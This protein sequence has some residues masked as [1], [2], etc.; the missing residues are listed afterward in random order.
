MPVRFGLVGQNG[1]DLAFD[2]ADRRSRRR[3]RHPAH[4]AEPD[5]RLPRRLGAAG[6]LAAARLLRAGAAQHRPDRGRPPLPAEDRRRP[7]QP[8]AGG[9]DA[10]HA[11][12]DRRGDRGPARRERRFR[13][14]IDRRTCRCRRERRIS[15]PLSAPRCCSCPAKPTSPA[16]SAATSI[17]TRS[18]PRAIRCGRASPTASAGALPRWSS[19]LA[20]RRAVLARCRLGRS[21]G[22]RQ[23]RARP[24]GRRRQP[25]GRRPSSPS[26]S[27]RPT[28]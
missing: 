5:D 14:S 3:R 10:G 7:V 19:R 12:A 11:R 6:A 15:R 23:R 24:D 20:D 25:A 16:R 18:P 9:A 13:R 8:L 26:A 2:S 27:P 1:E 21:P 28:T 17:R 4:R 22:A